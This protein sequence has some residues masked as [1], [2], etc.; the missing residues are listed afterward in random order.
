LAAF[1]FAGIEAPPLSGFS[2]ETQTLPNV[3]L[4]EVEKTLAP[5]DIAHY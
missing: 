2:L 1:F 4:S 3:T 5:Q